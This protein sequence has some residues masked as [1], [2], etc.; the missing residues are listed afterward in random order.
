[1]R[2]LNEPREVG[3]LFFILLDEESGVHTTE[4]EDDWWRLFMQLS[5]EQRGDAVVRASERLALNF[6]DYMEA[7]HSEG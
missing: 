3:N 6:T 4:V 2:N 7:D 5:P 1:M